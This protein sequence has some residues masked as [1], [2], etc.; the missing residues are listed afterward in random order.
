MNLDWAFLFYIAAPMI[1]G[2]AWLKTGHS[3]FVWII[4]AGVH[5]EAFR[6]QSIASLKVAAVHFRESYPQTVKRVRI[7]HV[8]SF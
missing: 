2:V 1:G 8:E 3:P 5:L 7:E 6:T 4:H